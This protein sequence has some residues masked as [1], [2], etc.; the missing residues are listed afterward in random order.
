[1]LSTSLVSQEQHASN[2]DSPLFPVCLSLLC[3]FRLAEEKMKAA[4]L[5]PELSTLSDEVTQEEWD[6]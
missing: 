4:T 3:I 6:A 2:P 1:M 5:Q